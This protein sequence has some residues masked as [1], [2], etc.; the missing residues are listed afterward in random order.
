[1]G[2]CNCLPKQGGNAEILN[3]KAPSSGK[4]IVKQYRMRGTPDEEEESVIKIQ[5]VFRG[6]KARKE[7]EL[8]KLEQYKKRVIGQLHAYIETCTQNSFITK[9]TPFDYE[10]NELL[11]PMFASRVFKGPTDIVDGGVYVGEWYTSFF[12]YNSKRNIRALFSLLI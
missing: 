2:A 12:P 11:D 6:H 4:R 10:E 9:Q 8:A 7:I 3:D 5:S 1:M